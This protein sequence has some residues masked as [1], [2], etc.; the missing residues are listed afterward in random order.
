MPKR[1]V[2]VVARIATTALLNGGLGMND[3]VRVVVNGFP[4]KVDKFVAGEYVTVWRYRN[5]RLIRVREIVQT[6]WGKK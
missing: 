1:G 5:G 6:R 4:M 2:E 3:T